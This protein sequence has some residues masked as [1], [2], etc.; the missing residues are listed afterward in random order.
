MSRD[1]TAEPPQTAALAPP[2]DPAFWHTYSPRFECPI[3]YV[4]AA[5][6]LGLGALLFLGLLWLS[7]QP[8]SEYKPGPILSTVESGPDD[9]GVGQASNGGTPDPAVIAAN[10]PT[11]KA[12]EEMEPNFKQVFPKLKERLQQKWQEEDPTVNMPVRDDK[13]GPLIVLSKALQDQLDSLGSPKGVG[14]KGK[15]GTGGDPDK[16]GPGTGSDST[17][18]R[19]MR[20]VI[21]FHTAGGRDYLDQL[22]ALGAKVVVPLADGKTTY[23][24]RTLTADPPTYTVMTEA[25]W[26]E[27]SG[28]VQFSDIAAESN[29]QVGDA[30]GLGKLPKGFWAFFPKELE[31]ELARKEVGHQQRRAEDIEETKFECVKKGGKYE[32]VVVGQKVKK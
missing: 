23:L 18:A 12:I 2:S 31:K 22:Q 13:I 7:N 14:D 10:T 26:P 30:L 29:Q 17:R 1:D 8:P 28:L 16:T 9:S 25:D 20:W 24:Y 11:Q 6:A 3:S 32:L 15:G 27:L 5:L 19:T 4:L 21:V